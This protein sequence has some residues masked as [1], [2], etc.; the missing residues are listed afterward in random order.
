MARIKRKDKSELVSAT[1]R[2]SA[3]KIL[4][5]GSACGWWIG[6]SSRRWEKNRRVRKCQAASRIFANAFTSDSHAIMPGWLH[7]CKKFFDSRKNHWFVFIRAGEFFHCIHR[8][9]PKQCDKF[10]F[11]AIFADEQFGA[12][13]AFDVSRGNARENFVAQ[14]VLVRLCVCSF[15]AAMPDPCDHTSKSKSERK[16][17][18]KR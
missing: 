2:R 17:K 4:G 12:A 7:S 10:D 18:W 8:I 5:Q 15:R 11:I 6:L 1:R 14:H 3:Q 16:R 9:E 13:I